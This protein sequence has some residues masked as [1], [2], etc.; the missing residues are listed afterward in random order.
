MAKESKLKFKYPENKTNFIRS[1]NKYFPSFL[2]NFQMPESVLD[3][4]VHL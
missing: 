1:K 3:F 4:R 2:K